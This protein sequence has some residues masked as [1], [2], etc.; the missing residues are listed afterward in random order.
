MNNGPNSY[1]N[2]SHKP[3]YRLVPRRPSSSQWPLLNKT[4]QQRGSLLLTE[5][6]ELFINKKTHMLP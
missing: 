3:E 5:L 1:K 6:Q 4:V 2:F